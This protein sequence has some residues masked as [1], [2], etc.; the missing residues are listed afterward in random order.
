MRIKMLKE[1]FTVCKVVFLVCAVA[2]GAGSARAETLSFSGETEK[3]PLLYKVGEEIIFNVTLVDKAAKN[4]PVKGRRL[5]WTRT[6]DDGK[7]EKGEAVSD[8]PLAIRTRID[9][10]GFVRVIV[11]VLGGDGK[12]LPGA[13]EKFDSSAGADVNDIPAEPRPADFDAFWEGELARMASVPMKGVLKP[14]D[15]KDPEVELS[16]FSV[17]LIPGEGPATGLIAWPKGAAA[18]SLPIKV[19]VPGYGYGRA[20]ISNRAVKE[21]KG[22]I[23]VCITRYGEDPLGSDD[24]HMN[25]W[26]NVCAGFAWHNLNSKNANDMFKM[27]MRDVRAVA[28]AK[29]RPEWDGKT[30]TV[31]G[32]SM[33]GYRSI[34]LAA[35]DR[36]VTSCAAHYAWMTD[37]A[38]HT[39]FN[40]LEGWLPKWTPEMAYVDGA[41]LATRVTCP[42]SMLIGLSDYV[43]PPSGE[44]ILFRNCKGPKSIRALQNAGH[45]IYYG[46]T[47]PEV[48]FKD[49]IR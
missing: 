32:G 23:V 27:V 33:G 30:L 12:P 42:V 10:P 11:N 49:A 26:T 40:R 29:T 6:G 13:F 3:N 22:R 17:N 44:M 34:A 36:D 45:G 39:N 43:C 20:A 41:N 18:K 21:D 14:V 1:T 7:T 48:S 8:G 37:L 15:A 28:F 31:G 9:K 24:Y 35:L 16:E 2:S 47:C 19:D 4:A 38:G 5:A 25:L 46:V